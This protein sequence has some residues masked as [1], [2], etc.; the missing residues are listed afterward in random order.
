MGSIDIIGY[1]FIV[2]FEIVFFDSFFFDMD[3]II[4]DFIVVVEKYWEG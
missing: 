3:G 4:I 1:S 2:G